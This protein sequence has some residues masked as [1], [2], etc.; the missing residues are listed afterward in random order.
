MLLSLSTRDS[1]CQCNLV[2]AQ[3]VQILHLCI[4]QIISKTKKEHKFQGKSL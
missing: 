4:Q 3:G 2:S 1:M